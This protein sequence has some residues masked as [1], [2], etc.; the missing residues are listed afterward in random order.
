MHALCLESAMSSLRLC[1]A[2]S[3]WPFPTRSHPRSVTYVARMST[4]R[5]GETHLS[6]IPV[7]F[8]PDW[9]CFVSDSIDIG[10]AI[11]TFTAEKLFSE[12]CFTAQIWPGEHPSSALLGQQCLGD[13]FDILTRAWAMKYWGVSYRCAPAWVAHC[14]YQHIFSRWDG[15]LCVGF[16]DTFVMSIVVW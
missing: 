7:N 16:D 2:G 13:G 12:V 6:A 10:C 3:Q 1:P 9:C 5:T 11:H 14:V 8:T 15:T 4:L